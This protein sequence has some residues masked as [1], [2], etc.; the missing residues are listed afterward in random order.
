MKL[1]RN[2]KDENHISDIEIL[3]K[4]QDKFPNLNEIENEFYFEDSPLFLDDDVFIIKISV[5]WIIMINGYERFI[6][7]EKC[8][9]FPNN[10]IFLRRYINDKGKKIYEECCRFPIYCNFVN[11]DVKKKIVKNL[12]MSFCDLKNI[13]KEDIFYHDE[14][15]NYEKVLIKMNGNK[16]N[17]IKNNINLFILDENFNIE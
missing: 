10:D 17:V 11:M 3:K 5:G 8:E 4:I 9:I 16:W 15:G 13:T 6:V 2:I 14:N 7:N 12:K 1:K